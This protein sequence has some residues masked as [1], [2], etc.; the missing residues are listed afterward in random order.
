MSSAIY[1][2]AY[3]SYLIKSGVQGVDLILGTRIIKK[4]EETF[5]PTQ[6]YELKVCINAMM[7][8]EYATPYCQV[9]TVQ[10]S[11]YSI[12]KMKQI[13]DSHRNKFIMVQPA[14]ES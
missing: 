4:K 7:T 5:L 10:R 11:T 14:N 6:K 1:A 9:N 8:S 13:Q 3:L 2:S 12:L